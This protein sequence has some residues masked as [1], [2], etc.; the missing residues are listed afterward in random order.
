MSYCR[1]GYSAFACCLI[2]CGCRPREE[3]DP[4]VEEAVSRIAHLRDSLNVGRPFVSE[5]YDAKSKIG[6]W[7]NAVSNVTLRTELAVELSETLL[8]VELTNQPYL[9]ISADGGGHEQRLSAVDSYCD[10][11]LA[12]FWLM[13]ENGCSPG[14]AM[15]FF[16]M[17]LQKYKEACFSVPLEWKPLP[18]EDQ[19]MCDARYDTA[20]KSYDSYEVHMEF[21]RRFVLPKLP[22]CWPLQMQDAFRGRIEPFFD[23]PSKDEFLRMMQPRYKYAPPLPPKS[24]MRKQ[25]TTKSDDAIEVDI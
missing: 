1:I 10:C 6:G 4:Q 24:T 8:S 17:A 2:L 13:N 12:A 9:A 25:E 3:P 16:F 11:A 5:M 19:R 14:K 15:D 7:I 20:R 22:D 18:G 21:I 23:F